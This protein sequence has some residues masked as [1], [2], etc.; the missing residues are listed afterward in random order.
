MRLHNEFVHLKTGEVCHGLAIPRKKRYPRE[1]EFFTMFRDGCEYLSTLNIKPTESRVF[2]KLLTRLDYKNWIGICQQTIAEELGLK[3]QNVGRAIKALIDYEIIERE[4][5]PN[6]KRRWMYR[7]NADLGWK[8]D[9][10][11]WQRHQEEKFD[12]KFG[13]KVL[14]FPKGIES[15]EPYQPLS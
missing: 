9:A 13:G 11:Q 2:Y 7:L 8:G 10:K 12:K 14:H 15:Q 6:D 4:R 5:D 1:T 3:K